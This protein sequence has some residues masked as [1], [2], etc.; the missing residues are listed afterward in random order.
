MLCR[1]ANNAQSN[2][3]VLLIFVL[4]VARSQ[5]YIS[6]LYWFSCRVEHVKYACRQKTISCTFHQS[7]KIPCV[8]GLVSNHYV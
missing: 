5:L 7:I 1:V 8:D 3:N 4:E 2:L 6:F